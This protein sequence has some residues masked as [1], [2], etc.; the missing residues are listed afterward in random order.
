M[1]LAAALI[2]KVRSNPGL[3]ALELIFA[4]VITCA[5]IALMGGGK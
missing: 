2:D 4:I 5:L 1:K 3:C